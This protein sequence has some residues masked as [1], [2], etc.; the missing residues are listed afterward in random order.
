MLSGTTANRER[1][2]RGVSLVESLLGEAVGSLYVER[3][4]PAQSKERMVEL[5]DTL[6]EAYR[7]RISDLEWMTP[8]TRERALAKLAAFTPKIGYPERWRD[9]SAV[10]VRRDDLL[11]SIRAAEAADTDRELARLGGPVD[12]DEWLMTPQ[13]VN[14]YYNPRMNEIVF[15]AAILQPPFFDAEADDAANY[16]GIG[17]VIGHEI[18]HG[19]DDQGSKYDGTGAL[20][21]WWSDADRTEFDRRT[22]A[23]VAQYSA[24]EPS[25]TPGHLVNGALTVG[26]NIGDLGGLSIALVAY[27]VALEKA[28]TASLEEAPVVDELTGLQ[29]VYFAWAQVWRAKTRPSEAIR[30]LAV[31]P[32]SPPELRTNAVVRNIDSFHTAFGVTEGDGLWLDPEER[33][34]IW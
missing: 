14:A 28:G 7:R 11:G 33:V 19:F 20:R 26:E 1:W 18:G 34:S 27:A 31:D 16:G 12:R 25:E 9:Y 3:H 23:L 21:D 4:F 24:L 10:T 32:H 6:V 2:K 17:A 15:P 22:Q 8:A 5:V 29:R 30:R 13:T